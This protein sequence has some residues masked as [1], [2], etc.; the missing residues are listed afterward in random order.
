MDVS[1]SE[2]IKIK[3]IIGKLHE[4]VENVCKE[5]KKILKGER[6][7]SSNVI[8]VLVSCMQFVEKFPIV[9]GYDKQLVILESIKRIIDEQDNDEV[10][11]ENMK[12]LVSLTLP[13]VI[14]TFIAIDKR[15]LQIK[16]KTSCTRIR[17][18]ISKCCKCSK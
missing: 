18:V 16:L 10:E 13:S 6:L 17:K 2:D 5:I 9:N 11:R 14:D 3:V 12:L 15:E 8:S 4:Y 1:C 7:C